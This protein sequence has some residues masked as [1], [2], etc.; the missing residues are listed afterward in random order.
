MNTGDDTDIIKFYSFQGWGHRSS[1][2]NTVCHMGVV[3]LWSSLYYCC[4]F[5]V[6]APIL[7]KRSTQENKLIG[8]D[9]WGNFYVFPT[10]LTCKCFYIEWALLKLECYFYELNELLFTQTAWLGLL[11]GPDSSLHWII[12]WE[13]L[14]FSMKCTDRI[15]GRKWNAIVCTLYHC[16]VLNYEEKSHRGQI[17]WVGFL[18]L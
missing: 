17:L 18:K 10:Y 15:R 16:I 6:H 12:C 4:L 5:N 8:Y 11:W 13:R 14:L 2:N 3:I 9:N 1:C 7:Y